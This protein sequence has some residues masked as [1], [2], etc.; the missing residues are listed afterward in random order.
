MLGAFDRESIENLTLPFDKRS[1]CTFWRSVVSD[2]AANPVATP[3]LTRLNAPF[4]ARC[5]LTIHISVPANR[6]QLVLM[7]LLALGAF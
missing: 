7:H 1:K 4:G 6:R 3:D 5:F 2:Y